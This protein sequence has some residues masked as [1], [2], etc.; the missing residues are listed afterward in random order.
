MCHL[1]YAQ[2]DLHT[3]QE[4]PHPF[5][6]ESPCC[7]HPSLAFLADSGALDAESSILPLPSHYFPRVSHVCV[8]RNI[9]IGERRRTLTAP[10]WPGIL[11][12]LMRVF[13]GDTLNN[14]HARDSMSIFPALR[15]LPGFRPS[16]SLGDPPG[17]A[18]PGAPVCG[19]EELEDTSV[20]L[21]PPL[22]LCRLHT[23]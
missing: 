23:S 9:R 11:P 4:P 13:P 10:N 19:P 2:F 3:V 7:V 14:I 20:G 22:H 8:S 21:E 6:A 16:K 15:V 1:R 18:G 12:A 5:I 17:D